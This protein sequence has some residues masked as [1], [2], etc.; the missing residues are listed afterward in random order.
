MENLFPKKPFLLAASAAAR[1]I[2][3]EIGLFEVLLPLR[4]LLGEEGGK[5]RHGICVV[6]EI[7]GITQRP[8]RTRAFEGIPSAAG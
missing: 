5:G 2:L 3:A 1:R 8:K 6:G 7:I 4:R